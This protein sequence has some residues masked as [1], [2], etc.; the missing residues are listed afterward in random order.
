MLIKL[1]TESIQWK[2][3]EDIWRSGHERKIIKKS[4]LLIESVSERMLSGLASCESNNSCKWWN[5]GA[6]FVKILTMKISA[7]NTLLLNFPLS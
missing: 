7:E 6:E 5:N 1:T 4:C 2:Q 3:I